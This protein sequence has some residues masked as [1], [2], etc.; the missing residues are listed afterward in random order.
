ILVKAKQRIK[1]RAKELR[2]SAC[3]AALA[4]VKRVKKHKTPSK[5]KK[6]AKSIAFKENMRKE[7]WQM[8]CLES[9]KQW[10]QVKAINKEWAEKR[11]ESFAKI[12]LEEKVEEV[13]YSITKKRIVQPKVKTYQYLPIV[14]NNLSKKSS[15]T[16]GIKKR[17]K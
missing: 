15:C 4:E 10:D 3:V 9:K 12:E 13:K 1:D 17:W 16:Y 7:A 5:L 6:L 11:Y 8:H 2:S 14:S